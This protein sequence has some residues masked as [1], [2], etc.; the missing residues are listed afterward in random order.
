FACDRRFAERND[1][2]GHNHI[3]D[4]GSPA[5]RIPGGLRGANN[6]SVDVYVHRRRRTG[7]NC[8]ARG[9]CA[10]IR[11]ADKNLAAARIGGRN[12]LNGVEL[13]HCIVQSG[14]I[15]RIRGYSVGRIGQRCVNCLHVIVVRGVGRRR[16]HGSVVNGRVI[17][18][19]RISSSS[20]GGGRISSGS[21]RGIGGGSGSSRRS[22]CVSGS[23]IRR[24]SGGIGG[25]AAAVAGSS[26]RPAASTIST[27]TTPIA[28]ST[29]S[30]TAPVG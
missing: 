6:H 16:G 19:G 28:A 13:R 9:K 25:A 5:D 23:S 20:I 2:S 1:P 4:S 18:G 22:R 29:T 24:S 30:V 8:T 14:G 3:A 27:P 7:R 11:R 17:R 21:G 15:G 12:R 26:T 10:R